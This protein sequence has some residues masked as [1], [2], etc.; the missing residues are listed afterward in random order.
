MKH[1]RCQAHSLVGTPN[2]I[3]PEVLQRAGNC[4]PSSSHVLLTQS[5]QAL[6]VHFLLKPVQ[7]DDRTNTTCL[8]SV[9]REVIESGLQ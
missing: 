4:Q 1:Q 7:I 8:L 9:L 3:A 5:N 6:H 2:Y